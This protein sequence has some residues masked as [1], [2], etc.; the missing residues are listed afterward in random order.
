MSPWLP[1]CLALP[2][3]HKLTHWVSDIGER[4]MPG[5]EHHCLVHL[6]AMHVSCK[7][8]IESK[9]IVDL[10]PALLT[11]SRKMLGSRSLE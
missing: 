4:M 11:E 6:V 7:G 10:V 9:G 2:V 8:V 3:C 1:D 5:I